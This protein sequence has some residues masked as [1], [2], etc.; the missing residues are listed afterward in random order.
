[1]VI[2]AVAVVWLGAGGI[3]D[4]EFQC[5][6]AVAHLHGC[7]P[8]LDPRAISCVYSTGCNSTQSTA[9]SVKESFCI[10][11]SSCEVIR[12]AQIC[13]RALEREARETKVVDAGAI[14]AEPEEEPE[15]EPVCP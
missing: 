15:E 10:Q 3:R 2:M 13:E 8:E 4:D 11:D 14:D 9:F 6:Q 1:M 7:C 5:E 12:L